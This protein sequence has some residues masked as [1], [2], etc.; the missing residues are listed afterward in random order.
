MQRKLLLATVLMAF[1]AAGAQAALTS[2][3]PGFN[4]RY[5]QS[6]PGVLAPLDSFFSADAFANARTDFDGGTVTYPDGITARPLTLRPTEAVYTYFSPLNPFGAV[7]T[8]FFFG[9]Y[10]FRL[11]QD[12]PPNIDFGQATRSTSHYTTD[13]P[14]L[15]NYAA[16]AGLR[17]GDPFTFMFDPFT[18]GAGATSGRIVVQLFQVGTGLV[19]AS[20]DLPISAT[21]ANLPGGILLPATNYVVEL[22][23]DSFVA[24]SDPV[25]GI[26]NSLLFGLR[27]VS[28]FS[29]PADPVPTPAPSGALIGLLGL[30][31]LAGAR[32][33]R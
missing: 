15:G 11:E 31:L 10:Q 1:G 13:L 2:V 22:I 29:V 24:G 17:S 7:D 9:T 18:P 32:R 14:V 5:L 19:W 21:S 23:H 26:N 8:A 16:L 6:A 3:Q 4:K 12:A 20:G 30:A 28:R 25:N 27:G 33:R